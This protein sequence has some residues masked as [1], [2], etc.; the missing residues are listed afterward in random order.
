ML[1]KQNAAP[2]RTAFSKSQSSK[3]RFGDLPPSSSETVFT[4]SAAAL[5]IRMPA[6]VDPV[7]DTT[8]MPGCDDKIEPTPTPSPLTMLKTP[9]GKPAS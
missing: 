8:S 1:L 7:N 6:R 2:D 4:V 5:L 3:T 9:G